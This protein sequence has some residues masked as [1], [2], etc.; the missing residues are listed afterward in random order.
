MHDIKAILSTV[1]G[2]CRQAAEE[3]LRCGVVPTLPDMEA[4]G[5]EGV[6]RGEREAAHYEA[7]V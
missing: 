4:D 2:I 5:R 7:A 6:M 3:L 1:P